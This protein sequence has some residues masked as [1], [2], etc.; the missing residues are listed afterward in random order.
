MSC[1]FFSSNWTVIS[2]LDNEIEE[3]P[4]VELIDMAS[5]RF[6]INTA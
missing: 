3:F 2:F 4:E 1:I 6:V 5:E